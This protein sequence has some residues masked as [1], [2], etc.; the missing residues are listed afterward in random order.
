M[1]NIK[2]CIAQ[3]LMPLYIDGVLSEE[4]SVLLQDHMEHCESCAQEYEAMSRDVVLP[5]NQVVQEENSR[6]VKDLKKKWTVKKCVI[7]VVS[8]VMTMTTLVFS[9]FMCREILFDQSIGIVAPPIYRAYQRNVEESDGWIRLTYQKDTR[10]YNLI[11]TAEK[12]KYLEFDSVFSELHFVN[13]GYSSGP[14]ELRVLDAEGNIVVEPF[15][16]EPGRGIYL[17]QLERDTPY[18]VEF[19]GEGQFFEFSFS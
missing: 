19:R 16:L 10:W 12:E 3:D 11:Q 15:V 13:T 14:V 2:C 17:Q 5:T 8:A 9:Y 1:D 7:A 18:I 4:S 6:V